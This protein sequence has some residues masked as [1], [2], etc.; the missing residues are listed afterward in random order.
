M[1]FRTFIKYILT[2]I[3]GSTIGF[4]SENSFHQ[5]VR[6]LY[7]TLTYNK[8]SFQM[9][10]LDLYFTFAQFSASFGFYSIILLYLFGRQKPRQRLINAFLTL[11]FATSSLLLYCY[12]DANI[13]LIECTMCDDGTRVLFYSDI[14]YTKI[15]VTTLLISLIPYLWTEFRSRRK[16][17]HQTV[18][19]TDRS[20]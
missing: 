17:K 19:A 6:H 7:C 4:F 5:L 10:K 3:L 9:P 12:F 15:F 20:I 13:E 16:A 11:V 18:F 2:F 14:K 1:K 8:I